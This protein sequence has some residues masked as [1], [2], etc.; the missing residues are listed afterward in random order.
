MYA[1]F[2]F[3]VQDSYNFA[4]C[5]RE[6]RRPIEETSRVKSSRTRQERIDGG[7]DATRAVIISGRMSVCRSGD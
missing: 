3:V 2:Q 7:V 6:E 5:A 1:T 4:Q